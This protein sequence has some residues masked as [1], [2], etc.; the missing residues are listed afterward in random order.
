M[1]R[2]LGRRRA[3]G[4]QP[5]VYPLKVF[6]IRVTRFAMACRVR[7]GADRAPLPAGPIKDMLLRQPSTLKFTSRDKAV[8]PV[9]RGVTAGVT[10]VARRTRG[11]E[12]LIYSRQP[13]EWPTS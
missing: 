7:A 1:L 2:D 6:A 8:W 5:A 3:G 10:L 9:T 13:H 4:V 11:R 12:Y